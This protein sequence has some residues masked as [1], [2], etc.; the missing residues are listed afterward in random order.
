MQLLLNKSYEFGIHNGLSLMHGIVK[1]IK[2]KKGWPVPNIGWCKVNIKKEAAEPFRNFMTDTHFYFIHSY[3][4]DMENKKNVV[5]SIKYGDIAIPAI[6]QDD[7]IIGCQFH[8]ELSDIS[9]FKIIKN[10]VKLI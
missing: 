6:I 9:G 7:N 8:P 1:P 4:C 2:K 3:Y 5:G 10:F